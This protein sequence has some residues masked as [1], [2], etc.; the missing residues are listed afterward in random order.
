MGPIAK[1]ILAW[2]VII[3]FIGGL[4]AGIDYPAPA[5]CSSDSDC[6][7]GK[8]KCIRRECHCSSNA[9]GD[10]KNKCDEWGRCP[11]VAGRDSCIFLGLK[12]FV[13]THC[14]MKPGSGTLSCKCDNGY[15]GRPKRP[16]CTRNSGEQKPCP[17]SRNQCHKKYGTCN[18]GLCYCTGLY[19]GDGLQCREVKSC[20]KNNKCDT[21]STDCVLDPLFPKTPICKCKLGFRKND[22]N[23][24]V[25]CLITKH[26]PKKYSICI[27][28]ACT[29]PEC[30]SDTDCNYDE[31]SAS[32]DRGDCKCK[33]E[34]IREGKKCKP[35][36]IQSCRGDSDCHKNAK[37][38]E[39]KCICQ[40]WYVG[41][42]RICRASRPCH[43]VK[44]CGSHGVCLLDPLLLKTPQCRCEKG[45]Q[46]Y[47][48]NG[49][50]AECVSNKDCNTVYSTC[51]KGECKCKDELIKDGNTC[52]P[53]SLPCPKGYRCG[54]HSTCVVDPL[55]PDTIDC[56]CDQG[57]KK[58]DSGSCAALS[59][60]EKKGLN[61]PAGA[62]CGTVSSGSMGCIC[63]EG[64]RTIFEN[65]KLTCKDIDECSTGNARCS[66][67][68]CTNTVGSYTCVS[69]PYGF[70][71][72]ADG[73]CVG[74]FKGACNCKQHE[75][76]RRGKCVCKKGYKRNRQRDCVGGNRELEVETGS[77]H[78]SH[79]ASHLC[80][81]VVIGV[82]GNLVFTT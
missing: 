77:G 7:K 53:D 38:E 8:A 78:T 40:G 49:I 24:C 26:C 63:K 2:V 3:F 65:D 16:H 82:L 59:D 51:I 11:I 18:K 29:K 30:A 67:D 32:C 44:L 52:R 54:K 57:Y 9:F 61:C 12:A 23:K 35:A 27:K 55:F 36:P 66:G 45:Y 69:C 20:P 41:N 10:G 46:I 37:C 75:D 80:T 14:L 21:H 56:K 73:L 6:F 71:D 25:E 42:G 22:D 72:G 17:T 79:F 19:V 68:R 28:Q 60:C 1:H 39:H 58:S 5:R 4:H 76:C 34:L 62:K 47:R 43:D 74:T 64:Y 33:D 13:N 70:T 81:L 50:C 48:K 31:N 15:F